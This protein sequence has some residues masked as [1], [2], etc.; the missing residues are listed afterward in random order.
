MTPASTPSRA[1]M[2]SDGWFTLLLS[3]LFIV[4]GGGLGL[5]WKTGEVINIARNSPVSLA[6]RVEL[7]LLP[8]M[9]LEQDEPNS[10]FIQRLD[11]AL[12][13][14]Q[15]HGAT[16]LLLG[17]HTGGEISEATAGKN[18]LLQRGMPD[19]HI[20]LEERS[21]NTLENMYNARRLIATHGFEQIAIT[22]NRYHLARCRTLAAGLGIH[23]AACAAESS[24]RTPLQQ[25]PRL[26]LEGYY[27]HWY[28]TG[29]HWSRLT[30]NRHS[31][32]R[33]S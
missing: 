32:A 2:G 16:V 29:K 33:I 10:D 23:A 25:W 7:I 21:R 19:T 9:R 26:L 30:R 8:C 31:L 11:R 6:E 17:G 22:S 18:Y 24:S 5:L 3:N 28:A 13:L 14:H 12:L 4:L 15:V 1:A 20:L 27:L